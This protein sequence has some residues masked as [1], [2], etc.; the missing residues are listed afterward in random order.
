VFPLKDNIPTERFPVVT[1]ALI[2]INVF[3]FLF[4]QHPTGFSSV[5]NETV[6]KYGAIPY[7]LTHPGEHCGYG[8]RVTGNGE[9]ITSNAGT[10][11]CEGQ[12]IQT[13]EGPTRIRAISGS[14]PS[15]WLTIFTAMFM[16]GGF[17]HI[18]GNM[19]FL[20]IF[21]NNVEDA[22]GPL[23]FIAFYLLGGIA[24]LALQVAFNTDST[25][26]TIGA[27]GAIAG[28]LGGYILLYPRARV[29]TL[30]FIIFFVTFIEIPAVWVLGLWFLQQIYFGV[31]D[32][33][34]PTGGGVAYFAHIGGF[35]F[36]LIFI[37]IFATRIRK[38]PEPRL[39]VY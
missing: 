32:L 14:E 25:V 8:D 13:S 3:V 38:Q 33:S 7:E 2:A 36:G 30:I 9:L 26:P 37:R 35:A 31:A 23:K 16:H 21:G 39:P 28:V 19:L 24:A 20:W 1:V 12:V 5:D 10:V 22:M 15:T 11:A 6:V 34:D 29:L 18:I 27:S 4:L 17:L